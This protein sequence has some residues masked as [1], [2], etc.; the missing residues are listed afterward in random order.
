MFKAPSS[1]KAQNCKQLKCPSMGDGLTN[2]GTFIL[3]NT[4]QQQKERSI[5]TC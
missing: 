5:G 3:R 1:I 2:C 4:A